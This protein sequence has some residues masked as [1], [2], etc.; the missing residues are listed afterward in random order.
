M[1]KFLSLQI[2]PILIFSVG[3]SSAFAQ[4]PV[5]EQIIGSISIDSMMKYVRE[6]SGELPIDIGNGPEFIMS[7]NTFNPGNE[8]A[9]LFLQQKF[10]EF[11]YSVEVQT[12]SS[13]GKNL[14]VT[15][16]GSIPTADPLI[17]C[18]HYDA[19]PGGIYNAPGADDDGSGTA[20][21]LEAARILADVQFEHP[22]IFALWDEEEQGLVGSGFYAGAI[23]ANDVELRAVINMDA[24][25]Y[26]GNADAKA[27]IHSRPIGNSHEIADSVFAMRD[28]YDIDL[29]L[30]L[31]VPGAGYSD[32][33]SFWNEG[34][35]A[36]LVIEEF[37]ADGNPF[38]HTIND[39]VEH[40]DV[41]YFEKLARLSIATL[42]TMA[43]PAEDQ[44]SIGTIDT[45]STSLEL[46]PNPAGEE[47]DIWINM[48]MQDRVAISLHDLHG[49][50]LFKL[51]EG[52]LRPGK[53]SF[54]IDL[55][56]IAAGA[57]IVRSVGRNGS[58]TIK[59]VKLP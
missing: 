32:H 23:A 29:D 6:I 46:F 25:A 33:A 15:K 13:T 36:I 14:I 11:G 43:V 7:R 57:Y 54:K 21:V 19:M 4:H 56:G 41:S 26:D 39:R 2:V 50:E 49:N 58:A 10:E 9:Q 20:A 55:K 16:P 24:I 12:F 42:A 34:Y 18:A 37:G 48:M 40:F 35:G 52:D 47:V 17:L 1:K 59:L 8:K 3:S 38:Y 27:R 30:I 44:I 53:H 5:V 31:T 45:P 22:I 28:H 51:H